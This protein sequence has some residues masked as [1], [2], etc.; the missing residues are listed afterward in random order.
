MA[1]FFVLHIPQE[2]I[3]LV[4]RRFSS[5][6]AW[7]VYNFKRRL[8]LLSLGHCLPELPVSLTVKLVSPN[9]H[10]SSPLSR[11]KQQ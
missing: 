11:V 7:H 10:A 4:I 5:Y 3:Y 8:D 6:E 9:E 2:I 1:S